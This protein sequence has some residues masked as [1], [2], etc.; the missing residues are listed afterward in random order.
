MFV[1]IKY[2]LP[3]T[4]LWLSLG[5]VADPGRLGWHRPAE[6][7]RSAPPTPLTRETPA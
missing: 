3:T 7:P 2:A 4:L 6:Q 5:I 1:P